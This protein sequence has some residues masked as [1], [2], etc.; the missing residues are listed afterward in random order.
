MKKKYDLII[1]PPD[2]IHLSVRNSVY[3]M[4]FFFN[5]I[6]NAVLTEYKDFEYIIKYRGEQQRKNFQ[7]SCSSIAVGYGNFI[8][9]CKQDSI[10]VG[11]LGTACLEALDNGLKYF[12]YNDQLYS[13]NTNCSVYEHLQKILFSA[14]N[15]N[16]LISNIRQ[17][18]IYREGFSVR[19]IFF[20]DAL[21]LEE[22]IRLILVS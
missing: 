19:E 21:K 10:I 5:E 4:N 3:D 18:N 15:V 6:V 20:N 13:L 12:S 2:S 7:I 8:D 14:S 1:L 22:I 9:Y 11:P 17:N 16:E